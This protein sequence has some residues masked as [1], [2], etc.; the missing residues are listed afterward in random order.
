[1]RSPPRLGVSWPLGCSTSPTKTLRRMR[2]SRRRGSSQGD[3]R[4][5][6]GAHGPPC[7]RRLDVRRTCRWRRVEACLELVAA[8]ESLAG[9]SNA[10]AVERPRASRR[11]S[12]RRPRAAPRRTCSI[13]LPSV[14]DEALRGRDDGAG[15]ALLDD[16]ERARGA[17][18]RDP[19]QRRVPRSR[20]RREGLIGCR[21]AAQDFSRA[22]RSRPRS[23]RR[24][25]RTSPPITSVTVAR[26]GSPSSS[27]V[28]TR[29]RWS[30]STRSCG[31][32]RRSASRAVSSRSTAR[33]PRRASSRRSASLNDDPAVNGIIVQ[34]P[35]PPTI[36]LRSVVD[37]IDP[38]KDIDGIHPLNAG[39]LRLGYDGFLPA[40]AHAAVEILRRSG[41]R[42]RGQ[43]SGRRRPVGGRRHAGG[44]PARPRERDGDG[45]PLADARPRRHVKDAEILVVAAGHPGLITRRHAPARRRRRRRRD[46]RRR[47][48]D[49]RR[50]RLRGGAPRGLGDHARAG[51]R[52]AP[53][54]RAAAR[55]PRPGRP[56]PGGERRARGPGRPAARAASDRPAALPPFPDRPVAAATRGLR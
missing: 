15:E 40:T 41:D 18:A 38:A 26:P 51:R 34:M 49:R 56:R 16:V 7:G 47:R 22:G 44:V 36:R 20:S 52:R 33:R 2:R 14:G 17:D 46:Q 25:A 1:M 5:A 13:N 30:T 21:E 19:R 11:C 37:A 3:R 53:D 54:E 12:A 42:D 27:A 43:A 6:G 35:L 24:S 32:A 23:A 55:P 29:R 45:L 50:R 9:R 39:L 4:R 28:E 8:A 31:A 48:G 10:N